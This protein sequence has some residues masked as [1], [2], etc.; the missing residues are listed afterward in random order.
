[1][2]QVPAPGRLIASLACSVATLLLGVLVAAAGAR[3]A[4]AQDASPFDDQVNQIVSDIVQGNFGAVRA[5]FDPLMMDLISED[6]LAAAW[7]TYQ[8]L[9]GAFAA[10]DQPTSVMRGDLT[11]VQV[12]VHLAGGDGEIRITFHPDGAIAGL[13]FLRAGVPVPE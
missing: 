2:P 8:E 5:Q 3:D 9:L 12:P 11:V 4:A 1:M 13:F 7:Q 10:A 6:G